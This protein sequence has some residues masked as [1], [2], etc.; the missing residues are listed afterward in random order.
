MGFKYI[1]KAMKTSSMPR[2]RIC[3]SPKELYPNNT[4]NSLLFLDLINHYF[5]LSLFICLLSPFPINRI[6]LAL[7]CLACFM[8][9]VSKV[10]LCGGVNRYFFPC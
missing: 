8:E 9:H 6:I 5:F 3:S 7:W 2:S 10:Y 1:H 4:L